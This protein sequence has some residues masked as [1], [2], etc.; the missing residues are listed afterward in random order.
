MNVGVTLDNTRIHPLASQLSF[1]FLPDVSVHRIVPEQ[2]NNP[3]PPLM[4][5]YNHI[6]VDPLTTS[7]CTELCPSKVITPPPL[8]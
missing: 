7:P 1:E 2:G 4:T 5:P 8:P 6:P 3:P